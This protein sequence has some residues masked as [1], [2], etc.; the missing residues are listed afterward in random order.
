MRLDLDDRRLDPGGIDDPPGSFDVD[1]GKAYCSREP[2][3]DEGLH[4]CP[5]LLQGDSVVVGDSSVW[6]PG[7]LVVAGLERERRVHQI[8]IDGVQPES[9][10][11]GLQRGV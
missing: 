3:I 1:I 6:K 11:T 8:K 4:R 10:Q 9:F 2:C 5:G 7:I